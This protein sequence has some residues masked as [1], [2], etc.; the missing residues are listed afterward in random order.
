MKNPLNSLKKKIASYV[1]KD[2]QEQL[3]KE[4]EK[5]K[6]LEALLG[7]ILYNDNIELPVPIILDIFVICSFIDIFELI[8]ADEFNE[9]NIN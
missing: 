4:T 7:R 9:E 1:A 5:R 6:Q 3:N 8:N 2:L